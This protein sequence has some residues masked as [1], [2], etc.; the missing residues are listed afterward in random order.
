[1]QNLDRILARAQD[2]FKSMAWKTLVADCTI[3][4]ILPGKKVYEEKIF[5]ESWN[6]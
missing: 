3:P 5:Y 2:V 1:M 6:S 4:D